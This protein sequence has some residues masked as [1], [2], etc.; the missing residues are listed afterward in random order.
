MRDSLLGA[1]LLAALA[2]SVTG[3]KAHPSQH[4]TKGDAT[5]AET[6]AQVAEI[7]TAAWNRDK[8]IRLERRTTRLQPSRSKL[9]A[10]T[11]RMVPR[12]VSLLADS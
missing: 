8:V 10:R 11:S 3:C 5:T 2:I 7:V 6:Q 12:V 9:V 1:A 4:R